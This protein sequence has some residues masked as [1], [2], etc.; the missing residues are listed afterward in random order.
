[1][2]KAVETLLFRR[3]LSALRALMVLAAPALAQEDQN[4]EDMCAFS[5]SIILRTTPS[6]IRPI[7]PTTPLYFAKDGGTF[8][9]Y[10]FSIA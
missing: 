2:S 3:V 7:P 9:I 4:I 6:R 5:A 10:S 1:M 8:K